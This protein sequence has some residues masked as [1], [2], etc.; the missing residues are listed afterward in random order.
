MTSEYLE[1]LARDYSSGIKSHYVVKITNDS[2]G[3][4]DWVGIAARNGSTIP[5]SVMKDISE[6]NIPSKLYS[7]GDLKYEI[8][9]FNYIIFSNA[10]CA[11]LFTK[12]GP[13][14]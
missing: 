7:F 8:S 13:L 10:K 1:T 5:S 6:V 2:S 4:T 12:L 11:I 14:Y 3:N 9:M